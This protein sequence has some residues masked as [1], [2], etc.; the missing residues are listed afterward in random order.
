MAALQ[1]VFRAWALYPSWFFADDYVLLHD[2]LGTPVTPGYLFSD[3][4]SN[5]IPAV[6]LLASLVVGSGEL[7]WP[8]AA[9]IVLILQALANLAALTM[10]ASLFGPRWAIL[11]PF[12]LYLS[13][14]VTMPAFM[15]WVA[16]VSQLPFQ[17]AFFFAVTAWVAYLRTHRWRWLAVT[18]LVLIISLFCYTKSVLIAPVLAYVLIAYFAEGDLRRRVVTS[19]RRYW[20]A[21]V[22]GGAVTATYVVYYVTQVPQPFENPDRGQFGDVIETVLGSSFPTSLLGGPWR[23]WDTTPPVVLASPPDWAVSLSWVLI[24]GIVAYSVLTRSRVVVGWFLL[25]AYATGL[26]LLLASSRGQL[27]GQLSGLEYRYLTDVICVAALSLGLVFLPLLGAPGGSEPRAP[28]LLL[29]TPRPGV[30]IGIVGAI[31]IGGVLSTAR[32]VN[33][34]HTSNASREYVH[35]LQRDLKETPAPQLADQLMPRDVMPDYTTPVNTTEVF[36]QLLEEETS[37]PEVTDKLQLID[38]HGNLSEAAIRTGVTSRPGP[39]A[40]CGWKVGTAGRTIPLTGS[41]FDYGWWLRIGYLASGDSPVT[42]TAGDTDVRGS[43]HRG[44]HS[45]FLRAD[46]EFDEVTI[47][48]LTP[49]TRVCVDTIEVGFPEVWTSPS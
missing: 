18:I 35:N 49:G 46:G 22:L 36:T 43:M 5:L 7:N 28:R 37:F 9:T 25:L 3:F 31:S 11:A 10:L 20:A 41:T 27:Y 6:R 8:L 24:A 40:N 44:L 23:W 2:A 32:Y 14:A 48:G 33:F 29:I 19:L 34:W 13:S 42:V 17:A 47:S 26:G 4:N 12:A 15:W 45:L 30:V 16:A 38:D 1:L 39:V 21:A